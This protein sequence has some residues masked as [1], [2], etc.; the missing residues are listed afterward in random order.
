MSAGLGSGISVSKGH[1]AAQGPGGQVPA[2]FRSVHMRMHG[3]FGIRVCM[4]DMFRGVH[5]AE[6][7][8]TYVRM[9]D[10]RCIRRVPEHVHAYA[11]CLESFTS[12]SVRIHG[13]CGICV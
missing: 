7:R 9:C 13:V 5:F 1:A 8:S 4:N 3:V 6:F 10:V 12:T 11:Q 2:E